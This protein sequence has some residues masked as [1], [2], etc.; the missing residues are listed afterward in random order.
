MAELRALPPRRKRCTVSVEPVSVE[1]VSVEPAP[2]Q[3]MPMDAG[4]AV[5]GSRPGV[6]LQLATRF[7]ADRRRGLTGWAIGIAAYTTL[8]ISFFPTIRDSESLSAAIEDYPDAMKEFLGGEA[9]FDLSSGAGFL[10]AEVYSF[11]LPLLLSIVAIGFGATMGGDQRNGMM[12]ALLSL[13]I[14][15]WRVVAEKAVAMVTMVL[16]LALLVPAVVGLAAPLVDLE[17]GFGNLMAGTA[18]VVLI[19]MFHGL[20]AMAVGVVSGRRATAIGV[21]TAVFA[22]GY[23]L[24]GLG[25]LVSWMEPVRVLSPYHHALGTNPLLEGWQMGSFVLLLVLC[26]ATFAA[27]VTLFDGRDLA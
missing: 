5:G 21:A 26:L 2:V 4:F 15:R 19:V 16:S 14:P 6:G 10:T 13:P 1:P 27:T 22:A 17:I 11:M 24:N 20:L 18:G 8:M 3:P 12:D 7:L 25:G 23:V 9:A